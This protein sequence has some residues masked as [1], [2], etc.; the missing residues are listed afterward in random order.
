MDFKNRKSPRAAF[1][2]YSGGEYFVTIC[3]H[4]MK[5]YFGLIKDQEI[6]Y[7]EVGNIAVSKLN[8]LE[9]H[10]PYL[11]LVKYI[12]MPNH[13]H[14]I[15]KL[16]SKEADEEETGIRTKLSIILGGYKQ[17]VTMEARRRGLNFA[18]QSRY[19]DRIIRHEEEKKR[20]SEYI[21]NNVLRWDKD[22]FY[23]PKE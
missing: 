17:S 7:S 18:W 20:I 23:S 11:N 1:H 15:M 5:H 4:E 16:D 3:T 9:S 13:I 2:D 8:E 19:H 12:V 21:T 14:A 22:C 10:Y 6:F